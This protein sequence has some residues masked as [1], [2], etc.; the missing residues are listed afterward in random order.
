MTRPATSPPAAPVAAPEA[1]PAAPRGPAP[2][3]VAYSP[4]RLG[5]GVAHAV[6]AVA[7]CAVLLADDS[8]RIVAANAQADELFGVASGGLLGNLVDGLLP[9]RWRE[10][11]GDGFR[12]SDGPWTDPS[13]SGRVAV[14]VRPDGTCVRVRIAS[15]PAPLSYGTGVVVTADVAEDGAS[16]AVVAIGPVL[17][18]LDAAV[19]RIFAAGLTIAGV[20]G[21]LERGGAPSEALGEV[22]VD[23]DRAA[24]EIRRAGLRRPPTD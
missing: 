21:R 4:E 12:E 10:G 2:A 13:Y 6:F 7:P 22:M 3:D 17:A 20:R 19:R 11:P 24:R 18:D 16:G 5:D 1:D 8:G 14:A 23:L 9:S 15:A